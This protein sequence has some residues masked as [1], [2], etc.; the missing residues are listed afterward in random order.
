MVIHKSSRLRLRTPKLVKSVRR[1]QRSGKKK[2]PGHDKNCPLF[3]SEVP[4]MPRWPR[5]FEERFCSKIDKKGP[6]ECWLWTGHVGNNGYGTIWL[7]KKS[8]CVHRHM[9][10]MHLHRPI[11]QGLYACHSCNVRRCVNPLHLYEGT[12]SQ[13]SQDS[14]QAGTHYFSTTRQ[15]FRG[16]AKL[17]ESQ[18]R[19]IRHRIVAGEAQRSLAKEFEITVTAMNNLARGK[20]W[21]EV[22]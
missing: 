17:S 10:E 19:T 18:V 11:S 15:L 20:T 13:N 7:N 8:V 1:N 9:L 22:K 6:N 3:E 2:G 5:T 14:V 4:I 21:K 12:P 16:S